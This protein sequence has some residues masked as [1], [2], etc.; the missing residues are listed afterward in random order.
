VAFVNGC[1]LELLPLTPTRIGTGYIR[2]RAQ[3]GPQYPTP[4]YRHEDWGH[5]RPIPRLPFPGEALLFIL[6]LELARNDQ[7]ATVGDLDVRTRPLNHGDDLGFT[8]LEG[9]W[10][11]WSPDVVKL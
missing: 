8:S 4:H 6:L 5:R 9:H 7:M 3:E 11:A 1:R 2:T 10:K